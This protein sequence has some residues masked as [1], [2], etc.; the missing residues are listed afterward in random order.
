M[1]VLDDEIRLWTKRRRDLFA[2]FFEEAGRENPED[3][4][5]LLYSLIEGTIQQYLLEPDRYPLQTIVNRI[6]E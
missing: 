5:Y 3:E 1:A 2:A 6:I 4:A